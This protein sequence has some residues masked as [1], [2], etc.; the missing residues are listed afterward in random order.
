MGAHRTHCAPNLRACDTGAAV[1][2]ARFVWVSEPQE[3]LYGASAGLLTRF[4]R[5]ICVRAIGSR[6]SLGT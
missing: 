3:H 5:V 4:F 2:A 1:R 6:Y